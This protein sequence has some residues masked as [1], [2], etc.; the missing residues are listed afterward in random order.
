MMQRGREG[1]QNDI[2]LRAGE[3]MSSA[4]TWMG[5]EELPQPLCG[6]VVST[7]NTMMVP[8]MVISERYSSG[9]MTPPCAAFGQRVAN[10]E[11]EAFGFTIWKRIS[12]DSAI[13]TKTENRPRK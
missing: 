8:C 12:K 11:T 2:M 9:V 6:T 10:H 3:A 13:P 4:P 1:G 7:K 5:R